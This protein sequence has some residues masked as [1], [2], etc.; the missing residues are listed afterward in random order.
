MLREDIWGTI[1]TAGFDAVIIFMAITMFTRG[2]LWLAIPFTAIFGGIG[3]WYTAKI[4][5]Y[6]YYKLKDILSRK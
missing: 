3:V 4:I 6:W 5:K 2:M 1:I